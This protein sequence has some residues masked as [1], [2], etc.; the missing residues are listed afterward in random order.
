MTDPLVQARI[1]A[2]HFWFRDGLSEIAAGI[3]LLL[4]GGWLLLNVLGN[5][6]SSWY[7]PATL[8]CVLLFAAFAISASR[9]MA[10]VRERITY[11]RSGYVQESGR[12]RRIVVGMTV[13]VLA[14]VTVALGVRYTGVGRWDPDRWTQWLPAVVGLTVGV[15]SAYVSVRQGLPRFFALGVFSI[16][17]G[18]AGSIEF[19]P[20]LAMAVWLA[21]VGCGWLCSGGVTLWKYIRTTQPSAHQT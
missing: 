20:K 3:I 17:L 13:A 5:S 19:Q 9:M 6:R 8:I 12:N 16:I 21:G 11:Q 1:R 7:T 2:Q 18:V 4:Q 15:V 10:A 14:T